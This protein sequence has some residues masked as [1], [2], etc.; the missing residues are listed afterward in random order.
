MSILKFLKNGR[1]KFQAFLKNNK[2]DFLILAGAVL[3][4]YGLYLIYEPVSY[5]VFGAGLIW[6]SYPKGVR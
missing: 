1:M 4:W 5:I 6:F 3:V 2:K